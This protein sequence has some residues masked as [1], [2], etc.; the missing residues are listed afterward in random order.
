MNSLD[1][2]RVLEAALICASQPL[3]LREMRAL[4]VEQFDADKLQALL[5][6]LVQ[7]WETRGVELVV[8]ADGWRMQSRPEMREY[9]DRLNPEKPPK[10][11][12]AVMETLAII[13]YRQPVTR[14]DIED[15]RGVAVASQIIKQ[16]EDRGWVETIGQRESAG[17]PS[18]LAT[19]A[20]FL[21]DLGLSRLEQLPVLAAGPG[22]TDP[23]TSLQASLLA[24]AAPFSEQEQVGKATPP[25]DMSLTILPTVSVDYSSAASLATPSDFIAAVVAPKELQE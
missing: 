23:S 1:A 19:T 13:A 16:L 25:V 4:F 7:D 5:A 14:G 11:S 2:K 12:R 20:K 21:N 8:L 18:L 9:L 6:E 3:A 24:C 15:I 22:W 17:R 10:Y